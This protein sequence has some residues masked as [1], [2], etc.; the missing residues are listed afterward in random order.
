MTTRS[1]HPF[2][3]NGRRTLSARESMQRLKALACT[4]PSDT[5]PSCSGQVFVGVF[6]DGT[7]N[8]MKADYE[9]PPPEQRKHTNIVKLFQTFPDEPRRGY[10]RYYVPGVGTPFPEIGEHTA[11]KMGSAM[12]KYG[13]DRIAWGLL[14]VLNAPHQYVFDAPLWEESQEDKTKK[15]PNIDKICPLPPKPMPR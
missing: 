10:L 9:T 11:S 4:L 15:F 8:N 1:P 14:R 3:E 6:F 13:E 12:A 7:G 5:K 2:P